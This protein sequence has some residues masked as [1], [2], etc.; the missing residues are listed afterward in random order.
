M[1]LGG[2]IFLY[3]NQSYSPVVPLPEPLGSN[4]PK[5]ARYRNHALVDVAALAHSEAVAPGTHK[6]QGSTPL[7]GAILALPVYIIYKYIYN[8]YIYNICV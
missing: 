1:L 6:G 7:Q 4:W 3:E 2:Y 5:V 8:I